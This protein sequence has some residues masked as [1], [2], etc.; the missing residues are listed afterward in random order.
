MKAIT[1]R[2]PDE[3]ADWLRDKAAT[4]TIRLKK[5]TSINSV[6]VDIFRQAMEADQRREA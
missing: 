3:L 4:E 2:M 1:F 6:A 5:V